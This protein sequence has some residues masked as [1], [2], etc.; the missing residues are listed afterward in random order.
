MRAVIAHGERIEREAEQEAENQ[1]NGDYEP[2]FLEAH[3]TLRPDIQFRR[4][5]PQPKSPAKPRRPIISERPDLT[6]LSRVLS[7]Y[8]DEDRL[9]LLFGAAELLRP[10]L[11]VRERAILDWLLNP[12]DR[13]L[14]AVA[15]EIGIT[16]SYASKLRGRVLD[17]LCKR[18]TAKP[19]E[20]LAVGEPIFA[21]KAIKQT[22]SL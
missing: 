10:A 13:T 19:A 11:D 16:K 22:N 8:T 21:A 4:P 17:L 9:G 15:K 18:M 5:K 12:G 6:R 14:T 2:V 20:S 7:E 1:R 3:D